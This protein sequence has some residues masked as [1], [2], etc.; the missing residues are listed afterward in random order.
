MFDVITRKLDYTRLLFS[1]WAMSMGG[2]SISTILQ[3]LQWHF[4]AVILLLSFGFGY[5]ANAHVRVDIFREMLAHR[6]QAWIELIGLVLLALPFMF[7]M[8]DESY[9]LTQMSFTQGEGSE[10]LS[11]IDKRW[12]IKSVLIIGF[13]VLLMAIVATFFRLVGFL[14]GNAETRLDAERSLQIFADESTELRLAREA[15]E[16]AL[17]E[18]EDALVAAADAAASAAGRGR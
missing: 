13:T 18:E 14:F 1:D 7:I 15:A 4:H 9:E 17:A 2:I 5:L 16:R 6:K 8:I 12:I 10:S 11:G 3:D